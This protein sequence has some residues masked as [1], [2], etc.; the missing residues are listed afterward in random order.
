MHAKR[1]H[2]YKCMCYSSH[3]S[4]PMNNATPRQFGIA[5]ISPC[6]C[7]PIVSGQVD[8]WRASKQDMRDAIL[9][10]TSQHIFLGSCRFNIFE[11]NEVLRAMAVRLSI[12]GALAGPSMQAPA[13]KPQHASPGQQVREEGQVTKRRAGDKEKG[14]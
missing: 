11:L 6:F 14:R 5:G 4:T 13:C 10:N 1:I 8:A 9:L 2:Q 3:N 7:V 12:N